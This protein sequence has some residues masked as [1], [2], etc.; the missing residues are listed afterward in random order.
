MIWQLIHIAES[1]LWIFMAG[2][3]AYVFIFAI[4][5]IFHRSTSKRK[6]EDKGNQNSFLIL[7]P[8]YKEDAVIVKSVSK[9]LNQDYP[10]E[11]YHVVVISDHNSHSTNAEL[12]NLGAEV[13]IPTFINSSKAKALKLAVKKNILPYDFVI[14]LDADNIVESNF[15]KELNQSCLQG[16]RAIQCHRCA[17]NADNDIAALDGISEEINNNIFRKA[18]NAIGLSAALI[19]SGMCID[20]RW[21]AQ[22]VDKL[23]TAGEDKE[24]EA[25]LICDN[26][27]IKYEN[28]ILVYDE[29][30]SNNDNFQRQRKRWLT[31]QLQS[32]LR[33]LPHLP[34]ET[35]RGNINYIDKTIQQAL[36]PRSILVVGILFM[37]I[38]MS[39]VVST[40]ATKWWILF[41]LYAI[42]LYFAI[43]KKMRSTMLLRRTS[44]L[45]ALTFKMIR[46]MRH[47][48]RSD[49]EFHHTEHNA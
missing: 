35:F 23:S 29:K 10:S 26:I 20:Y 41:A 32:L 44:T 42:S 11:K 45:F 28:T 1:M 38:I 31:A 46:G 47:I 8:A 2:S 6:E 24:L 40:W 3:V 36:V 7:F 21:F 17:K 39:I 49:M 5:S 27:Y 15:L 14:I 25:L 9:F 34:R 30:V 18:H 13:I 37:S 33:M 22:N 48:K 16:Y 4:I 12:Q 19:G 43:P